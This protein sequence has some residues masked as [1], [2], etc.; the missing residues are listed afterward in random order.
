MSKALIAAGCFWG[1]EEYFRKINGV[2]N[3]KVGYS[4]GLSINPNYEKVCRGNTGHAEVVFVEYDEKILLYNNII[5]FFWQ[6]HDPTQTNRQ[7]LDVGTQY[8]SA[9]F[10]YNVEQKKIAE[11]SKDKLQ[12]ITSIP[13]VTEIKKAEE[14]YLAEEYHQ[15][16]LKKGA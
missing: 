7:G 2:N 5:D 8:R 12:K 10:Y 6:C 16:Y 11:K 13:I 15:C 3:T 14:F 4:G 9:I 1:V